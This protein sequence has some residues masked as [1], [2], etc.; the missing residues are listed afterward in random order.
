MNIGTLFYLA[1]TS[2]VIN[3]LNDL[4][5]FDAVH[6]VRTPSGFI[7]KIV[8]RYCGI[9]SAMSLNS[10]AGIAAF[11]RKER[12]ARNKLRSLKALQIYL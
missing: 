8:V 4:D 11:E 3:Q 10:A 5:M 1:R 2:S 12:K 6:V 7:S 9:Q